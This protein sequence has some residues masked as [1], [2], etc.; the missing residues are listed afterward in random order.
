[1][2]ATG[3]ESR[4]AKATYRGAFGFDPRESQ[5]HFLVQI[6]RGNQANVEISEHFEWDEL[7]GSSKVTMSL[8][9]EEGQLRIALPR[10]KWDDISNDLAKE[11][12]QRLRRQGQK[13]GK[14]KSG[15]NIV[16]RL[17]GKELVLLAW[18]IE[19][20]DRAQIPLAVRNWLGLVPEERWW[21]YTMAAAATGHFQ[22]GR[23]RGW[24]KAVGIALTENPIA[25][26]DERRTPD[27]FRLA[28]G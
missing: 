1:M 4:S 15:E 20:A 6:P 18:A 17:F 5:H 28:E 8:E 7:P 19:D 21:L 11:F 26:S 22:A 9:K 25:L 27:F 23:G 13:P 12:N 24:R 10:V 3:R 14:W 2:A 16:G